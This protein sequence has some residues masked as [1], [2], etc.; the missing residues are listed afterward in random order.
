M[1][2]THFIKKS[3]GISSEWYSLVN[4]FQNQGIKFVNEKSNL[5]N[6]AHMIV[7]L[8][9]SPIS[10]SEKIVTIGGIHQQLYQKIVANNLIPCLSNIA[11]AHST[12]NNFVIY[13]KVYF[14]ANTIGERML[15]KPMVSH[16]MNIIDNQFP[17]DKIYYSIED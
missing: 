3:V 14:R 15:F 12:L 13:T 6:N 1:I 4:F 16:I 5:S 8:H 2:Q 17:I 9:L 7:E 11:I 10:V